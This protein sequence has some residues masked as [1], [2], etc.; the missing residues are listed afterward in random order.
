[1]I[2]RQKFN[3]LFNNFNK[4]FVVEIIDIFLS[5][6]DERFRKL[7]KNVEEKDFVN[8]KFNAHTLKGVVGNF[9]DPVTNEI[10]IKFDEMATTIVDFYYPETTAL[11][12]KV[13]EMTEKKK[14]AELPQVYYNL[15]KNMLRLVEELKIIRKEF[16]A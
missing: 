8:L 15:E 13:D 6:Y 5:E 1:M 16:S 2:D 7:H 9:H 4:E 10:A 3:D 14:E 11:S 12:K